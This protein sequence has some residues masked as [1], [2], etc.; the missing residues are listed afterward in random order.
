MKLS[1]TRWNQFKLAAAA[2]GCLS[3]GLMISAYA[4]ASEEREPRQSQLV[5]QSSQ[6]SGA[7]T[8][9][10]KITAITEALAIEAGPGPLALEF[11][12]LSTPKP[13]FTVTFKSYIE[14]GNERQVECR[15]SVVTGETE[16]IYRPQKEPCTLPTKIV[17]LITIDSS[18]PVDEVIL[19]GNVSEWLEGTTVRIS[20][21][22]L[23]VLPKNES[24]SYYPSLAPK[25]TVVV[26]KP[27]AA[28]SPLNCS[29]LKI[30]GNF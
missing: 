11:E 1:T 19:N 18:P 15:I 4:G 3:L 20:A 9:A 25:G 14:N 5:A 22:N 10:I 23:R 2:L 7:A 17:G 8:T 6:K 13:Y 26:C 27:S 16:T 28:G 12:K 24:Y 30:R 21:S 29:D